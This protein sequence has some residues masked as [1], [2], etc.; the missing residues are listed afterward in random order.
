MPRVLIASVV[1][2]YEAARQAE[3]EAFGK[4][5]APW[6]LATPH[7]KRSWRIGIEV[8]V[9]HDRMLERGAKAL[10]RLSRKSRP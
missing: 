10:Q 9:K 3:M 8:A 5:I 7:V 2:G 4:A 1:A 6:P